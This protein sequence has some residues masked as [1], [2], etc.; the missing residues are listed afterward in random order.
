MSVDAHSMRGG[1]RQLVIV[2]VKCAARR[3]VE[4]VIALDVV[5][6]VVLNV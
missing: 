5:F 3:R 6:A 1:G 4:Y 2:G